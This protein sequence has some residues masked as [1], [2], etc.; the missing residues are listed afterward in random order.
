MTNG[1]LCRAV[2]RTAVREIDQTVRGALFRALYEDDP[3]DLWWAG[4]VARAKSAA[5]D[6][7][8]DEAVVHPVHRAVNTAVAE[9][10]TQALSEISFAQRA[11]LACH[12]K[13]LGP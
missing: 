10:M 11:E 1:R 5:V 13:A 7:A 8:V 3:N 12:L 9:A 6:E 2:E 4:V